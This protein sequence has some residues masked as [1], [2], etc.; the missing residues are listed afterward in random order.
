[1]L[2]GA[3]ALIKLVEALIRFE[4]VQIISHTA[5]GRSI[6]VDTLE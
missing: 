6:L 2:K 1:M 5:D 3:D 4:K